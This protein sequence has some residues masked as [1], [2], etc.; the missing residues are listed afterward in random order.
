MKSV[1]HAARAS[2][3]AAAILA[4]GGAAM[5]TTSSCPTLQRDLQDGILLEPLDVAAPQCSVPKDRILR[6]LPYAND[7]HPRHVLDL[8]LPPASSTPFPTVVWI[9]GGG[10]Q[11]GSRAD[12]EQVKRL[13]CSG[14]A[15]ASIDYRLSVPDSV[16]P[17]GWAFPTQIQDVKAAIRFLRAKASTYKLD[18][19]RIATFGSSAGG[20]LAALAATS[21]GVTA[22]EDLSLGYASTSSGVQAAAAWYGPTNFVL[23][24]DQLAAQE[25]CG[26][27]NHSDPGSPE[28]TLLACAGGLEDEACADRIKAADPATY[29]GLSTPPLQLFHGNK[30]CTVPMGQSLWLKTAVDNA[31][32]CAIRRIVDGANHG[33]RDKLFL[34]WTSAPVQD[35]LRNFFDRVLKRP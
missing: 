23:M 32:R 11:A 18:A 35:E 3:L 19:G 15:V 2:F 31:G 17:V 28:S 22:L 30:D 24:D 7:G 21:K 29:V 1:S 20:H 4:F 5:A 26:P 34:P 6:A 12:V 33:N 8:Y 16:D 27:G 25:G 13:V 9:H 14:Y 10:W